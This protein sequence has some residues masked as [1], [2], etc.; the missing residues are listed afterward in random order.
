M[1]LTVVIN[2]IA[3]QLVVL[4]PLAKAFAPSTT[5]VSCRPTTELAGLLGRFRKKRRIEQVR[6]IQKGDSLPEGDIEVLKQGETEGAVDYDVVSVKELLGMGKTLLVG[7]LSSKQDVWMSSP[8]L[9]TGTLLCQTGMPGAFT[10]TCT[11]EHLPGYVKIAPK[12]KSEGG[13]DTI[14]ILTT[15]DRYV[16]EEW[17]SQQGAL[18]SSGL[19][20]LSD[21]DGDFVKALGLADDMGFGVGV[22][23]K[24]FAL[25]LEDGKVDSVAFDEGMDDCSATS[26]ETMLKVLSPNVVAEEEGSG[27]SLGVLAC[28]AAAA[29]F[30]VT[31][32]G[33]GG[34]S[35]MPA[36]SPAPTAA[37]VETVV[38]APSAKAKTK[39]PGF[40]LLDEYK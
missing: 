31:Q 11:T 12:L 20:V 3:G 17:S 38:N 28:V 9:Y 34:L 18:S 40:S 39:S 10:P 27:A 32:S 13:I 25:V 14:A 21:G 1:R 35:F 33:G 29:V 15:N 24:R 8:H 7:K 37:N 6:T 30:A 19:V 5:T 23:S 16:N 2:L 22:R 36:P 26:A 4:L